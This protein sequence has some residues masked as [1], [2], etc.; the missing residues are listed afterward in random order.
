MSYTR[1]QVYHPDIGEEITRKM[2]ERDISKKDL[3]NLASEFSINYSSL[4]RQVMHWRQ[5]Y[6]LG[7][8]S[9]AP[10]RPKECLGRLSKFMKFIGMEGNNTAI[11]KL[12][13]QGIG[14]VY[15]HR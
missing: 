14:F 4:M 15:N 1:E 2:N 3:S 12:R 6:V 8:P 10:L 9:L 7:T 13:R 11:I 5:G